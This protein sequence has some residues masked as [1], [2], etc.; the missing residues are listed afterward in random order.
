VTLLLAALGLA[1]CSVNLS[2]DQYTSTEEKTF[3]VSGTPELVL[4]TF[5]GSIEV[6]SWDK[7]EIKATFEKRAESAEAAKNLV[8]KAE[9]SGNRITIDAPRPEPY[10]GIAINSNRS[11]S[12]ILSVPRN[13]NLQAKS[14]DGGVKLDGLEGRID[15]KSG[16]G[17]ISGHDL[18]GDLYVRTGDGGVS[19]DAVKG[20]LDLNTGDGGIQVDGTLSKLT[21]HTGDGSVTVRAAQGS[22]VDDDW[23]VTSGDGSVTLELP[24]GFSAS[25]DAHTGDGGITVEG[26]AL[27]APTGESKDTLRGSLGSGGK[28]VRLR[29]GDGGIRLRKI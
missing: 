3:Q 28:T 9:Q 29:T 8:V 21:A 7:A 6:R 22:R 2:A 1:G 17:G 4:T 12:L 5:D 23:D 13:I 27:P 25:V 26:L 20:R 24:D 10:S 15:V 14:G 16:D 19:L 11:V 18:A